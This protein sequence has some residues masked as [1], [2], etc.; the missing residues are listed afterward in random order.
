MKTSCPSCGQH[1]EYGDELAGSVAPCPKCGAEVSFPNLTACPDCGAEV[2]R[3]A[4]VCPRCGAPVVSRIPAKVSE[5]VEYL[6]IAA[7]LIL[8]LAPFGIA[9]AIALPE[10]QKAWGWI[11]SVVALVGAVYVWK[12]KWSINCPNCG[13]VGKPRVSGDG[14]CLLTLILLVVGEAPCALYGAF[15]PLAIL[16]ETAL[17]L[18]AVGLIPPLVCGSLAS[19]RFHCPVCGR[20]GFR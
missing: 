9:L 1:L 20:E 14:G 11:L 17:L 18:L 10:G 3:R 5:G 8:L 6:I 4:E 19:P 15:H 2:S 12:I 16:G 7:L 13:Y